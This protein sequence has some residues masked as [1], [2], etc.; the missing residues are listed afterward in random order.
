MHTRRDLLAQ[1]LL[2]PLASLP[3]SR[4]TIDIIAGSDLLSEESAAGFRSL[5]EENFVRRNMI[6]LPAV[7]HVSRERAFELR[8]RTI[9]GAWIIWEQSPCLSASEE[10][11]QSRLFEEVFRRK[12]Q[13]R[14]APPGTI[15]YIQYLRPCKLL[16]RT[17]VSLTPIDCS[18]DEVI[19]TC[20]NAQVS[21]AWPTGRGGVVFLGS[22]LGPHLQAGDREARRLGTYLLAK[23]A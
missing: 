16:T 2:L 14:A 5:V 18:A 13:T 15:S 19:G 21:A 3:R 23:H 12:L 6:I 8:D 22:M 10:R 20:G 1:A 4:P 11:A 7:R 17:F 9:R